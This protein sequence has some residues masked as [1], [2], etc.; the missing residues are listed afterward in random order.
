MMTKIC[1][2]LRAGN[3][4][5]LS[6][7]RHLTKHDDD[8]DSNTCFHLIIRCNT[9]PDVNVLCRS[10]NRMFVFLFLFRLQILKTNKS[11]NV[12]LGHLIYFLAKSAQILRRWLRKE[13]R[14]KLGHYRLMFINL[15]T[16]NVVLFHLRTLLKAYR[17]G[18]D[19]MENDAE[20]CKGE[21]QI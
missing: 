21:W 11:P 15:C 2:Q 5:A 4:C 20:S 9:T 14:V 6:V 3:G 19:Q 17:D 10:I 1:F 8:D 12:H 16:F 13:K 18:F 7:E